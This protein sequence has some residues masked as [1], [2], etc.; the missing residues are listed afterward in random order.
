MEKAR[1]KASLTLSTVCIL[2]MWTGVL[3]AQR[4]TDNGDGTVTDHQSGLIWEKKTPAGSG[5][6][7]DVNNQYAWCARSG[8]HFTCADRSEA[9]NGTVFTEF[10]YGLNHSTS[11]NGDSSNGCFLGHCDW[12]LPTIVELRT[13]FDPAQGACGG[14]SGACIDPIFGP[15]FSGTVT[16]GVH[17][18]PANSFY[19]SSTSFVPSPPLPPEAAGAWVVNFGFQLRGSI[20]VGVLSKGTPTYVRAVRGQ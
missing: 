10:L 1:G 11:D 17:T 7:H 15:T 3:H 8:T 13:I 9:P 20:D 18:D 4:F 19:W 12:R 2:L 14:G 6:L 5:G 16:V